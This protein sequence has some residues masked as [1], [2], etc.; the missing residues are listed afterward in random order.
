M[1]H[2]PKGQ[3]VFLPPFKAWLAS[4]IPAV[5][6]NTMTYYEELCALIKY[7]QDVVIPALNHNAEA[8]T[9]I[10]TAVEQLQK[11]VEDYF[12]NLD[13]QEEINNKLDAMVES[14][15]FQELVG[16]YLVYKLDYYEI[17][18]ESETKLQQLLN[19]DRQL[20]IRFMN[21]YTC[22]SFKRMKGNKI[23][24]LNNHTL[25]F[26]VPSIEEDATACHGFWNFE[27]TDDFTGYDG[28]G[29]I[30]FKD[31]TIVGGNI[32]FCHARNINIKNVD[33]KNC[34]NG[35]IL[36]M[37]AID[38]LTVENCTF[39]G[40]PAG[41]DNCEYIQP[42]VADHTAFPWLYEESP[43]Y[44]N[45]PCK[46][47]IIRNCDF[48]PSD[49]LNY[50]HYAGFGTHAGSDESDQTFYNILVEKCRFIE[51]TGLYSMQLYNA[52]NV[53]IKD[54]IFD[55]ANRDEGFCHLRFRAGVV[56]V[57]V[58]NSSFVDG[59]RCI[60]TAYPY[61]PVKNVNIHD[62]KFLSHTYGLFTGMAMITLYDPQLCSVCNNEFKD[63][64]NL[65]LIANQSENY[66]ALVDY[67]IT[68]EGNYLRPLHAVGTQININCGNANVN[69]NTFDCTDYNPTAY[70][71][72]ARNTALSLIASGNIFSGNVVAGNTTV[73]DETA[74]A[75]SNVYNTKYLVWEGNSN[76]QE[77]TS[78]DYDFSKFNRIGLTL[79]STSNVQS[80][81]LEPYS[82]E[83]K[84]IAQTWSIPVY[85][86][87]ST[88]IGKVTLQYD[89]TNHKLIYT[90]DTALRR[91]YL[92][93]EV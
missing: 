33:F 69:N 56:N 16:E 55:S 5:Y 72:R 8:V 23:I 43:T 6:D 83:R 71:V 52:N 54:C 74:S 62:C 87:D 11:Y 65:T 14:G 13:V 89:A 53:T 37:C 79:G 15:E 38:G 60:Q 21:D 25:T 58:V 24:D 92:F 66:S 82:K 34:K 63:F 49:D 44:D 61:S 46:N 17:T 29:D 39:A 57:E 12:K 75:Y 28:N 32:S 18:D 36:E 70:L 31:G 41:V 84:L 47:F 64:N 1:A 26:N 77:I 67:D 10:A 76:S 88:S 85:P 22:T 48:I 30:T 91:L 90:G 81:T 27:T 35:H 93:N 2:L 78:D 45:T 9:T 7:L 3:G 68:V 40:V 4:N 42:D 59:A 19:S 73:K 20:Y 50:V 86:Q 51:A 80:F